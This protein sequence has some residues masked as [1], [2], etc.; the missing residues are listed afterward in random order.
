[1]YKVPNFYMIS[2]KIYKIQNNEFIYVIP[3]K[4]ALY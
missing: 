4:H 1:M 2:E 3:Q